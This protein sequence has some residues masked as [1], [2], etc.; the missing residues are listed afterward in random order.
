MGKWD[1]MKREA[2]VRHR[3]RPRLLVTLKYLENLPE[4]SCSLPTGTTPGKRWKG[5]VH[6]QPYGKRSLPR[7]GWMISE[8]YE[9]PELPPNR[10]GIHWYRP[11][12]RVKAETER[13]TL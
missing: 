13:A 12:I 3:A 6:F 8:Y 2:Q 5:E 11:V 9:G 10:I 1:A 4:Y 7:I